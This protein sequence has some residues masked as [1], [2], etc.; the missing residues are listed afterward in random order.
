MSK[1]NKEINTRLRRV[2]CADNQSLYVSCCHNVFLQWWSQWD[3]ENYILQLS[4]LLT[5]VKYQ[6]TTE[7]SAFTVV[8][9]KRIHCDFQF[10]VYKSACKSQLFPQNKMEKWFHKTV[11][12]VIGMSRKKFHFL[13]PTHPPRHAKN[14]LSPYNGY[15][16]HFVTLVTNPSY[17]LLAWH[18]LWM[19]TWT[20]ALFNTEIN[21]IRLL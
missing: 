4:L 18:T 17:P 15:T 11:L 10:C 13:Y 1:L 5:H 19:M 9:S 21:Q 8:F 7:K 20:V 14:S 12:G 2:T 16:K 6:P 3:K